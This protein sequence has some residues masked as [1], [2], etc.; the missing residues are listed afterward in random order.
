M[1]RSHVREIKHADDTVGEI[2][3]RKPRVSVLPGL[4]LLLR[5]EMINLSYIVINSSL[6]PW[7]SP[8]IAYNFMK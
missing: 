5:D 8:D 1:E 3:V 6:L 2:C 4:R 7:K